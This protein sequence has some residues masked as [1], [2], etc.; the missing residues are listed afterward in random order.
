MINKSEKEDRMPAPLK[1]EH[2]TH[3]WR[4]S[5][6]GRTADSSVRPGMTYGGKCRDAKNGMHSWVKER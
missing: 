4:C 6:C 2:V 5:K 1:K 3:H